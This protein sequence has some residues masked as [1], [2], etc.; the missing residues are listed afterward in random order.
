MDYYIAVTNKD[1]MKFAGKW[2]ELEHT[3]LSD[4]HSEGF[5]VL[6]CTSTPKFN[7]HTIFYSFIIYL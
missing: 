7:Q 6:T 1:I 4:S 2:M 3:I 5:H